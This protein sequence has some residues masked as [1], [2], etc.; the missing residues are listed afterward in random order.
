MRFFDTAVADIDLAV[1][2]G[3]PESKAFKLHERKAECLE[4]M[5]RAD[6]AAESYRLVPPDKWLKFSLCRASFSVP[7]LLV[8]PVQKVCQDAVQVEAAQ[9]EEGQAHR[10]LQGQDQRLQDILV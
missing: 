4:A 2:S 5:G 8:H 7:I 10:E 6:E 3:Y 9:G 1:A